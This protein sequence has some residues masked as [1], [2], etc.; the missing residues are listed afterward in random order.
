MF[1]LIVFNVKWLDF[2]VRLNPLLSKSNSP[3]QADLVESSR[4]TYRPENFEPTLNDE[5][6]KMSIE[7]SV[8]T[9]GYKILIHV[10]FA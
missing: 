5:V 7:S 8:A 2:V 3:I 1:C 4:I 10:Y 6:A 9:Q